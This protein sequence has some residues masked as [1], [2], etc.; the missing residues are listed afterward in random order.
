LAGKRKAARGRPPAAAG[1]DTRT[2]LISAAMAEF[3]SDGFDGTDTNRIARRAGYAPQTFYRWFGHKT[4][5]FIAAYKAWEDLERRVL[6][7]LLRDHASA[8]QLVGAIVSHHSEY[9]VFRRSLRQ[10]SLEN[11]EVRQARA[12][13]R[14]RQVEALQHWRQ[15]RRP[16]MSE[17]AIATAL[18][19]MERLADA[20]AEHELQDMTL[21]PAAAEQVL[22][23]IIE[24]LLE[25]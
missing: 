22:A 13:S 12:A 3:N 20:L 4:E 17:S 5:I 23:Q 19:Q 1:P 11:P 6:E 2:R 9:K 10:L 15:K 7:E 24:S 21:N 8:G 16:A 14:M 18:L 25:T